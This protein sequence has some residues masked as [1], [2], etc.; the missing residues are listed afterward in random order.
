VSESDGSGER[1]V[2]VRDQVAAPEGTLSRLLVSVG[3]VGTVAVTV[4]STEITVWS[5][6][7]T[8]IAVGGSVAFVAG[9][10]EHV[11]PSRAAFEHGRILV[12]FAGV[13]CLLASFLGFVTLEFGLG[14]ATGVGVGSLVSAAVTLALSDLWGDTTAR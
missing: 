7:P 8:G 10:A 1:T 11:D 14:V 13:L 12:G 3:A 4:A 5:V 9:V 6:S 2:S